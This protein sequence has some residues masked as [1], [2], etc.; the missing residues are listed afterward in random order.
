M[1]NPLT[2]RETLRT[3]GAAGVA[4]LTAVA[5][6][7]AA[8]AATDGEEPTPTRTDG[9][10]ATGTETAGEASGVVETTSVGMSCYTDEEEYFFRPALIRVDPG[11]AVSFGVGTA[12]RQQALAYHPDNDAPLRMPEGAEPWA[13]PVMQGSKAGTFEVTFDAA[14]VYDYFGLHEDFGQVGSVVVGTP[15]PEGEPGLAPPQ[16]SIPAPARDLLA[17]LN[18][19]TRSYLSD[20]GV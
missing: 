12:C 2:R 13:S 4:G 16:E 3:A 7:S 10:G 8:P 1:R 11:A 19:R 15:D 18:E 5:G 14:G 20:R 17:E 9:P 6:C